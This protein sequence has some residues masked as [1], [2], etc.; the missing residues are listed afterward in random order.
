MTEEHKKNGDEKT[1]E[2]SPQQQTSDPTMFIPKTTHS[3]SAPAVKDNFKTVINSSPQTIIHG[4]E[5]TI[6]NSDV[7]NKV[8]RQDHPTEFIAQQTNSN[9]SILDWKNIKPGDTIGRYE[10]QSKIGMGGMGAVFKAFDNTLQRVVAIKLVLGISN[11]DRFLIEAQTTAKLNH[12]NIVSLYDIVA[13]GQN[14]FAMVMEYIN[15]KTLSD[16]LQEEQALEVERALR[17]IRDAA[18]ALH[19]AHEVQIIHR[20]IKPGNIMIDSNNI[21]KVTDFGLA[22]MLSAN[23]NVQ[24]TQPNMILGTPAYMSPE[25]IQ[26]EAV[27][28]KSDIYSLGVTLYQLLSG[29]LPIVSSD[30]MELLT[31]H[32]QHKLISLEEIN[33]EIPRNVVA[34][35][36]GM[37]ASD[38]NTR[39]NTQNVIAAISAY[40]NESFDG[41]HRSTK[42]E[43]LLEDHFFAKHIKNGQQQQQAGQLCEAIFEYQKAF[44]KR[45]TAK[46]LQQKIDSLRDKIIEDIHRKLKRHL[47]QE[48]MDL[49]AKIHEILPEE[50]EVIYLHNICEGHLRNQAL[51]KKFFYISTVALAIVLIIMSLPANSANNWSQTDKRVN[52][53][54]ENRAW[55]KALAVLEEAKQIDQDNTATIDQKIVIVEQWRMAYE[56]EIAGEQKQALLIYEKTRNLLDGHLREVINKHLASC[57]DKIKEQAIYE[58]YMSEGEKLL[59]DGLVQQAISM[60]NEAKKLQVDRLL[61]ENAN[62][63]IIVASSY[64]NEVVKNEVVKNEVAV[65]AIAPVKKENTRKRFSEKVPQLENAIAQKNWAELRNVFWKMQPGQQDLF[66]KHY[67]S[68]LKNIPPPQINITLPTQVEV[69][70]QISFSASFPSPKNIQLL[71]SFGDG[72]T[73]AGWHVQ[74]TYNKPGT[75]IVKLNIV[76]G[77]NHYQKVLRNYSI[78]QTVNVTWKMQELEDGFY[79]FNVE[80]D[81]S[82]TLYTWKF[83]DGNVRCGKRV[84]YKFAYSGKQQ[85]ELMVSTPQGQKSIKR[86]INIVH[87]DHFLEH[88]K[89][90]YHRV[91]QMHSLA[92]T[93]NTI[94]DLP[95][96]VIDARLAFGGAYVILR[97]QDSR[98][99]QVYNLIQRKFTTEISLP[100]ASSIFAT[101]GRYLLAYSANN[102]LLMVY[103]YLTQKTRKHKNFAYKI[104]DIVMGLDNG[105]L[106]FITILDENGRRGSE[107][108]YALMDTTTFSI[109]S[110]DVQDMYYASTRY[111]LQWRSDA[112]LR[113]LTCHQSSG[114]PWGVQ[115]I[116]LHNARC[117]LKREH[118]TKGYL[119]LELEGNYVFCSQGAILKNSPSTQIHRESSHIFPI[120]GSSY[121]ITYKKGKRYRDPGTFYIKD[122]YTLDQLK[123]VTGGQSI[124]A[125]PYHVKDFHFMASAIADTMIQIKKNKMHVLSLEI[126]GK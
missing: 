102:N 10:I 16:I 55:G 59:E 120:Y 60:F 114:S 97:L 14:N 118:N 18:R 113:N 22:K 25:Q 33:P 106:A 19:N 91:Q 7:H 48:S 43:V 108:K 109:S 98:R 125:H 11:N 110:F 37:L 66:L 73:K 81:L 32:I 56:K 42:R 67:R 112:Y 111:R 122:V 104:I 80:E 47:W 54:I 116:Y 68:Q 62:R 117:E 105:R 29:K 39:S 58:T 103:D 79:E 85:I 61:K 72:E 40:L 75:F 2:L 12:P 3:S 20:D 99:L 51:K 23:H 126:L 77:I 82:D 101:G 84:R 57:K 71:W 45:P 5:Q 89:N 95:A 24:V 13:L 44:E 63:R 30:L 28:G 88:R 41:E 31:A 86:H 35:V 27:D 17:I 46:H 83:D 8:Q 50:R 6:I 115:W 36:N 64:K 38:R 74:H 96:N 69:G 1:I 34:I 26:G 94:V 78:H 52:A 53:H 65:K 4:S 123:E 93:K 9:S 49:C 107:R 119:P 15:G 90:I 87:A 76:D 92:N 124:T 100:D 121:Y 70:K 21:V